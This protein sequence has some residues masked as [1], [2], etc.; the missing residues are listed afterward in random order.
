MVRLSYRGAALLVTAI[1][2]LLSLA[3]I[4]VSLCDVALANSRTDVGADTR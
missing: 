3:S 4:T 1:V 2:A